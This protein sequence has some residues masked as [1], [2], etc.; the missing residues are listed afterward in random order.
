MRRKVVIRRLR[1][2]LSIGAVTFYNDGLVM[3]GSGGNVRLSD[4]LMS[5]LLF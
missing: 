3:P 5:F 2:N 1:G 4:L